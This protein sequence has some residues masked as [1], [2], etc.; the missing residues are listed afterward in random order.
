MGAILGILSVVWLQSPDNA[1][2]AERGAYRLA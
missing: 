2:F 1:R